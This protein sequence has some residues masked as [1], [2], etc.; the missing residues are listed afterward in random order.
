MYAMSTTT[1]KKMTSNRGDGTSKRDALTAAGIGAFH[2]SLVT[3]HLSLINCHLS[4]ITTSKRDALT[5]AGIGAFHLSLVTYHFSLFTYHP[6]L[7]VSETLEVRSAE[8]Y[9][10]IS[11]TVRCTT[12]DDACALTVAG[13]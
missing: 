12:R 11:T 5:A 13:T 1:W 9:Y 8:Q 7:P 2:L 10:K 6:S 4:P 3:Y